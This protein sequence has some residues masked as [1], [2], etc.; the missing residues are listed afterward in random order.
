MKS[1]KEKM[2][3]GEL[4]NALDEELSQ[5]RKRARLL[6]AEINLSR[7]DKPEERKKILS[8][9]LPNFGKDLWLQPPFYCDYGTNIH[10]GDKVFFN[11]NCVI[12]DV[13]EVYIGSCKIGR[14]SCR[15]TM[16]R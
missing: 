3:S 5:E 7:E 4:Y 2:L 12:L 11:F 16:C 15:E 9:L 8:Q 1:E 6:I 13:C 14:A 10:G